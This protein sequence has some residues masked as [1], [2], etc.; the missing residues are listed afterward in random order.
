MILAFDILKG[1]GF[2]IINKTIMKILGIDGALLLGE[3]VSEY[4]YFEKADQLTE[5]GYFFSKSENIE[6]NT[7]LSY[8]KQNEALKVLQ[9]WG[10]VE[11][12]LRGVPAKKYFKLN[13]D[14]ILKFTLTDFKK[15][16]NK[17]LNPDSFKNFKNTDFEKYENLYKKSNRVRENKCIALEDKKENKQI[18]IKDL[19]PLKALEVYKEEFNLSPEIYESFKDYLDMRKKNGDKLNANIVKRAIMKLQSLS[20]DPGEQLEIINQSIIGCWSGLFPLKQTKP[21]QRYYQQPQRAPEPEPEDAYSRV[22]KR[23]E[24]EE[25]ARK[26]EETRQN[27]YD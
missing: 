4:S 17:D 26:E 15:F 25:A 27:E 12:D 20:S 13:L 24:A 3:L 11:T 16:E 22:R 21:P 5:D 14:E 10:F 8:Y 2:V 1:E 18:N 7:T 6:N 9:S 23:L 19:P